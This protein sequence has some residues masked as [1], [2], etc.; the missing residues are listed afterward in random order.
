MMPERRGRLCSSRP[1]RWLRT[2]P[3]TLLELRAPRPAA[4]V[5]GRLRVLVVTRIFPNRAEPLA[6]AFARQQL[7]A[8]A[9]LCDVEVMAGVPY[10]PGAALLGDR[11]RPGRLRRVP[12]EDL[13]AGLP[14]VHPRLPYVPGGG[15]LLAPLNAPLYLAGLAPHLAALRGRFDVVL[16]SFLYPDA[17]GAAMLARLLGLPYAVKTHGTDVN[18][19]ASWR[20]IAPILRR[21]LGGAVAAIGVSRPIAER[22]VELGAPRERTVLVPNGVDRDL[23]RPGDRAAARGALGLPLDV[24]VILFVGRLE[25]EKGVRELV[26]ATQAL[27]SR[28]AAAG[29]APPRLALVGD[30]SVRDDALRGGAGR[31]LA[32]GGRPLREVAEWLAAADVLALPSWAEGTPNVVLE[33]LASGRPVVASAVGG[34]PDVVRHGIDGLL[35]PPR[36]PAALAAALWDALARPWD[37]ATLVA[38]APPSWHAS[39]ALLAR[40][41]GAGVEAGART[42][43]AAET[44]PGRGGGGR[45]PRGGAGGAPR[46]GGGGPPAPPPP[47]G[48]PTQAPGRGR[49]ARSTRV[50][51]L[52]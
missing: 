28:R 24:P 45:G 7:S 10:L 22:L 50:A 14:V 39:A 47:G 1:A 25:P 43:E 17:C 11:T 38:A 6:C 48:P 41:L 40:A 30:G 20:S 23:F 46:G 33:A 27:A 13:I 12:R 2:K 5:H 15:A 26:A 49:A 3:H 16:G 4:S 37:E 19:V 51:P 18:V 21:V 42:R 35:V 34:I 9:R 31:I 36:D 29:L 32:P 52:D 44:A 8:L